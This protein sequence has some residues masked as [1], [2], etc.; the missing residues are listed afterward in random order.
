MKCKTTDLKKEKKS[1]TNSGMF[2]H[3]PASKPHNLS[4]FKTKINNLDG[5]VL[6]LFQIPLSF[7]KSELI[8]AVAISSLAFS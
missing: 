6:P 8:A 3:F 5:P 2:L 7:S 1:Y 4:L